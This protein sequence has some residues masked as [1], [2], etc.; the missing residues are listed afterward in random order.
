LDTIK[1]TTVN[2]K[3]GR[4]RG[5]GVRLGTVLMFSGLVFLDVVFETSLLSLDGEA[6]VFV[7]VNDAVSFDVDVVA[8]FV[9][10]VSFHC[11][12][13]VECFSLPSLR[14]WPRRFDV[15][16]FQKVFNIDKQFIVGV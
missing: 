5:E 6:D 11:F 9:V 4:K 7:E 8:V 16:A 12:R 13:V 1:A 10:C 3:K 15:E 2:I 14:P